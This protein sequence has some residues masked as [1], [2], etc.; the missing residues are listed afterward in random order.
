MSLVDVT[1]LLQKNEKE[2][3]VSCFPFAF[4]SIEIIFFPGNY[5]WGKSHCFERAGD[6]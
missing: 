2:A 3:L 5:F 4:T 6:S 1:F